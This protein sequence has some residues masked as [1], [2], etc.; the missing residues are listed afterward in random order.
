MEFSCSQECIFEYIGHYHDLTYSN[1]FLDLTYNLLTLFTKLVILITKI[2]ELSPSE[3]CVVNVVVVVEVT[4]SPVN[5]RTKVS[6]GSDT[7]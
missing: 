7:N 3:D 1:L 5:H 6:Q 2:K 4:I